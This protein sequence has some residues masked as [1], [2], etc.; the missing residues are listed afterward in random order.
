MIVCIGSHFTAHETRG[1]ALYVAITCHDVA[2]FS[3]VVYCCC[4][5]I[6]FTHSLYDLVQVNH[7]PCLCLQP[8]GE[9]SQETY[10]DIP[11]PETQETYE[12]INEGV[13]RPPLP[14][15]MQQ[16]DDCL[17]P[18]QV[19]SGPAVT[20]HPHS[21][22]KNRPGQP[23]PELQRQPS[24]AN[25]SL[26]PLPPGGSN[27]PKKSLSSRP[28]PNVPGSDSKSLS[29]YPWYFGDIDRNKATDKIK[30]L[31]QDGAYL[32]R[33]SKTDPKSPYT[34]AI[35]YK[36]KVW[37]LHIHIRSDKKFAIGAVKQDEQSFA[38]IVEL[39]EYHKTH[40]IILMGQNGGETRLVKHPKK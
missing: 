37:N 2:G 22:K 32:I 25:R 9:P 27:T 14:V 26:P 20:G 39:V 31:H 40:N 3:V 33:S 35:F 4:R 28:L 30:N 29:N 1:T 38:N 36:S 21:K 13:T 23:P 7:S 19:G 11:Q 16:Q 12:D 15:P 5:T 10:E 24:G 6:T 18:G 17:A 34:L 8:S